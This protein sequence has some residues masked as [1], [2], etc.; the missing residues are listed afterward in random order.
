MVVNSASKISPDLAYKNFSLATEFYVLW[1]YRVA[2]ELAKN[3]LRD[4]SDYFDVQKL[5]WFS[6]FA[7]GRYPEAQE[8][9]RLYIEH[10]PKDAEAIIRLWEIS[11]I[12]K[13]YV[14]ANLYLNNAIIA[15]YPDKTTIE[16]SLA[17]NY[18][19]LWDTAAMVKVLSYLLGEKDALEDD[20]AVAISL[21]FARGENAR[22]Y[23][24]AIEWLKKYPSSPILVPMYMMSLRIMG[25][26]ADVIKFSSTLTGD[27]LTSPLVLL[28]LG[29]NAFDTGDYTKAK[30]QFAKVYSVDNDADFGIEAENYLKQIEEK[31][32]SLELE[33]ASNA[34]PKEEKWWWF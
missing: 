13:N 11:A 21:A 4:R 14:E 30:E 3:I 33:E 22:A 28:E 16:R 26:E 2:Y 5:A 6:L 1:E 15:G 12:L 25:R 19:Q 8:M 10:M 29:I 23:V 27:I 24:W 7:L 34:P 32:K 9:L 20:F 17:Y 31:E 18:S